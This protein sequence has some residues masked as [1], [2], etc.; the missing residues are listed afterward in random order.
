MATTTT[1][2]KLTKVYSEKSDDSGEKGNGK[3]W[4]LTELVYTPK[5]EAE[6][7]TLAAV[8]THKFLANPTAGGKMPTLEDCFKFNQLCKAQRINPWA[9]DAYLLGYDTRNGAKFE[10]ITAHQALL[11]RADL[12][13]EYDGMESGII[14]ADIVDVE[15]VEPTKYPSIFCSSYEHAVRFDPATIREVPGD[16]WWAGQVVIG[17]WAKVYRRDRSRA[18]YERLKREVF[19]KRKSRWLADFAGMMAKVAEAHALREAFPSEIGGLYL[20]EEMHVRAA[21]AASLTDT[22]SSVSEAIGIER[23]HD[24]IPEVEAPELVIE[25]EACERAPEP[26]VTPESEKEAPEQPEAAEKE[27]PERGV[28]PE[29]EPTEAEAEPEL[30]A[31]EPEPE[32]PEPE[33]ETEEPA[34]QPIETDELLENFRAELEQ[35]DSK[36]G[37]AKLLK[38]WQA[39][40]PANATDEFWNQAGRAARQ[41]IESLS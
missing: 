14:I 37:V 19:D 24:G 28:D 21:E 40:D 29:P 18:S 16:L 30:E 35:C 8:T 25:A 33:A 3:K 26:E 12:H 20:A 32:A 4:Q 23:Q 36:A 5:G 13:P 38:K 39:M 17:G 34:E 7:I 41:Q 27:R 6:A 1:T 22:P 10:M 31:P 11:K 9:G 2:K 15:G